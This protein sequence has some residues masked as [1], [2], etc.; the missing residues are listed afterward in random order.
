MVVSHLYLSYRCSKCVIS[1]D[2]M[3][4]PVRY[5]ATGQNPVSEWVIGKLS[6]YPPSYS[7]VKRHM[8]ASRNPLLLAQMGLSTLKSTISNVLLSSICCQTSNPASQPFLDSLNLVDV[9]MTSLLALPFLFTNSSPYL[10]PLTL[11]FAETIC[12]R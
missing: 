10:R 5:Y 3:G 7:Q 12:P 11:S 4:W 2:I 8:T 9:F 6:P 1:V